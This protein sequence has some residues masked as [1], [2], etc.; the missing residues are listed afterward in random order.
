NGDFGMNIQNEIV[1]AL[2]PT[3]NKD[4]EKRILLTHGHN[5]GVMRDSDR[6][7]Y[8]A[9]EKKVDACF[10]GH[11]HIPEMRECGGVFIMNPGSPSCPRGGSKASYGI[12]EI[13]DTGEITGKLFPIA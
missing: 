3:S 2:N 12:V 8:Y 11:T 7:A 10:Y 1:L 6:L 4:V 13:S 5:L 9:R